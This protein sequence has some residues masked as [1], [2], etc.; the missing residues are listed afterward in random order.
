MTIE[1]TS[2]V[3]ILAIDKATGNVKLVIT[4][5]RDWDVDSDEHLQLLQEKINT[6]LRF[7]ESG[8][9]LETRPDTRGRDVVIR[10]VGKHPL[11]DEAQKFFNAAREVVK[12]AGFGLEFEL[13]RP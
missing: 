1:Q 9:M 8:E 12:K 13:Y 10:I 4:D 2:V 3:D 6:Y 11:G 5:H 7:V